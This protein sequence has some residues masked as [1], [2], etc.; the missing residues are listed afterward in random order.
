MKESARKSFGAIQLGLDPIM[1]I[2]RGQQT[3]LPLTRNH[4]SVVF[5]FQAIG[6]VFTSL[7]FNENK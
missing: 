5:Q 7:Y 6:N 4:G 1:T 3:P 2:V